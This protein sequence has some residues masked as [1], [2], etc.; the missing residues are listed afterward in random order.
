MFGSHAFFSNMSHN[1][2]R[3]NRIRAFTQLSWGTSA[4][5]PDLSTHNCQSRE[6]TPLAN[7]YFPFPQPLTET[8]FQTPSSPYATP[9]VTGQDAL[10]SCAFSFR[11]TEKQILANRL[12]SLKFTCPAPRP[13][14]PSPA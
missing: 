4:D 5:K 14:N 1:I 10:R 13:A 12:N 2:E 9:E 3:V 7:L 11:A 6:F 8:V